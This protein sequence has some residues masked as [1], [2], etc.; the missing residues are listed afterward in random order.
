MT[1]SYSLLLL[2][3]D[4]NSPSLTYTDLLVNLQR[5]VYCCG[6]GIKVNI[7]YKYAE[8]RK[9]G[10]VK[11]RLNKYK[12]LNKRENKSVYKKTVKEQN[13]KTTTLQLVSTDF[14]KKRK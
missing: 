13:G 14:L 6:E 2:F 4:S 11:C 7:Q 12:Q 1:K 10:I 5:G 8:A 9:M 3:T